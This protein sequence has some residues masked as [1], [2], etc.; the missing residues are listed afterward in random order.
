MLLFFTPWVTI[1]LAFL[2]LA[3]LV[4]IPVALLV[5]FGWIAL[6]GAA[7]AAAGL[8]LWLRPRYRVSILD[9]SP[10]GIFYWLQRR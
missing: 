8:A 4:A 10:L 7:A 9:S 1:S 2:G 3:L 5:P 6:P